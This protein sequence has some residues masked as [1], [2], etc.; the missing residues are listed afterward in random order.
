MWFSRL[1]FKLFL[2]Y[3]ALNLGLAVAY[4]SL[5]AGW[6][7]QLIQE[8]IELRLRDTALAL[9]GRIEDL[10]AAGSEERLEDAAAELSRAT[11]VRVTIVDAAGL[12]IA[13][14]HQD[15]RVMENHGRRA[16]FL[17]AAEQGVGWQ[18]LCVWRCR[19]RRLTAR[20]LPCTA[21]C[22]SRRCWSAGSR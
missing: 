12:V 15:P 5:L 14:S 13:D 3:A 17:Q 8:Q 2:V 19:W 6:Q 18:L 4:V 9:R 22:G 20:W 21:T 7:R 16:E 11:G 10:L 1:S